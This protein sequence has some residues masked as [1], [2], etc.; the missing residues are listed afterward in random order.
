MKKW[1]KYYECFMKIMDKKK[2]VFEMVVKVRIL[3]I[4]VIKDVWNRIFRSIKVSL[5]YYY[6]EYYSI[7]SSDRRRENWKFS[8]DFKVLDE[9]VINLVL[10]HF[11]FLFL[12]QIY[13]FSL[14]VSL[15]VLSFVCVD[16]WSWTKLDLFCNNN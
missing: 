6:E 8:E 14:W 7:H 9:S 16:V 5:F 12:I 2:E 1:I 10:K 3:N 15:T 11:V 4:C 13:S